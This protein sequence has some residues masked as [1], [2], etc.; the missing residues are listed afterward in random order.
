MFLYILY[1]VDL[2]QENTRKD[3]EKTTERRKGE[4]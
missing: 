1:K 4:K 2:I 3:K